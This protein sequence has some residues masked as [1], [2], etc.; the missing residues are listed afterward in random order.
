MSQ[1]L[2]LL[3]GPVVQNYEPMKG[4]AVY[5]APLFPQ[6]LRTDEFLN[7]F[8]EMFGS[9]SSICQ[10]HSRPL[11]CKDCIMKYIEHCNMIIDYL[12]PSIKTEDKKV[13]DTFITI[14]K[15]RFDD[16]LEQFIMI[17]E[18]IKACDEIIDNDVLYQFFDI[19]MDHYDPPSKNIVNQC[20]DYKYEKKEL[21][22]SC[23]VCI[24][25]FEQ[26]DAVKKLICGHIFHHDCIMI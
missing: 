23:V 25:D 9:K 10:D 7:I 4:L 2:N 21:D 6:Q 13:L 19:N 16:L 26:N 1:L 15:P 14:I 17:T 5:Y 18:H 20:N 24:C 3:F 22:E 12:Q 8:A 11:M